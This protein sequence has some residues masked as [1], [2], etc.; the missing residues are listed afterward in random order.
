MSPPRIPSLPTLLHDVAPRDLATVLGLA[1]RL[2]PSCAV[3]G[4]LAATLG[5]SFPSAVRGLDAE[6]WLAWC[7]SGLLVFEGGE[8]TIARARFESRR[9]VTALA[10]L[11]SRGNLSRA[12]RSL[13]KSRKGLRDSLREFELYPWPRAEDRRI[14]RHGLLSA[15]TNPPG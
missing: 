1:L 5:R 13:G 7:L 15:S 11:R 8:P 4:E 9:T 14:P 12:A 2:E 3:P 6:G 10:L